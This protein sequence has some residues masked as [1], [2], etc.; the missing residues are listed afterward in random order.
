MKNIAIIGAGGF[1]REVKTILDAINVLNPVYNF[2]GFYDDGFEK[3][4]NSNGYPIL[5]GIECVNF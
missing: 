1:G 2:L 4:D 5:G 3:G